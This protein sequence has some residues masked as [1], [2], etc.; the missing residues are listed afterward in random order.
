[1]KVQLAS[2]NNIPHRLNHVCQQIVNDSKKVLLSSHSYF[3]RN[4][5]FLYWIMKNSP[6]KFFISNASG[7]IAIRR[8][9]L[10]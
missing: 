8:S 1:M 7:T 3:L 4:N 2:H 9:Q 5:L 10:C 6:L